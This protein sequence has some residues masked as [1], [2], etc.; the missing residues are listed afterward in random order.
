MKL[1]VLIVRSVSVEMLTAV[2]DACAARWPG[3]PILVVTN[4][5]RG[6]ELRA[7]PR[8]DEIIVYTMGVVG[9]SALI[10]CPHALESV[11]VPVANYSGSG[12]ANVMRAARNLHTRSWFIASHARQ[13]REL[14][15]RQWTRRWRTE[16]MLEPLAR[17]LGRLWSA[18]I[19]LD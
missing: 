4:P 9:F 5:A 12:Y 10:G 13:L 8:I 16:L 15:E 2:L 6:S 18:S 17:S 1:P 7:D 19:R 14:N 3:H 11:V